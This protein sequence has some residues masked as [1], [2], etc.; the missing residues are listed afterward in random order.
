MSNRIFTTPNHVIMGVTTVFSTLV[1][2]AAFVAFGGGVFLALSILSS[3]GKLSADDY[4]AIVI[5]FAFCM[6][7]CLALIFL[8]ERKN[9]QRRTYGFSVVT[10]VLEVIGV[11]TY[12]LFGLGF[13]NEP[14]GFVL[15]IFAVLMFISLIGNIY[16]IIRHTLTK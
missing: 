9:P 6:F 1:H 13:Y 15:L 4:L 3:R 14:Y 8:L 11:P 16:C 12:A 7:H 5:T 2:G 10:A